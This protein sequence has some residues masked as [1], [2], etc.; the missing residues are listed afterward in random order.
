MRALAWDGDKLAL[1]SSHHVP[2]ADDRMA[3]V[4]VNLAGI[5][6]TDLQIFKGYMGFR[7]VPGHEFVGTV[8]DGPESL[9]GKRVVGEINFG[10]GQCE[11]CRRDLNRHCPNRSVMGILNAAGAFAEY[12]AVPAANLH[13]VP[14]KVSDEEAVF[15]EPLAAAFEILE[16][17]QIDPGDQV[18]VLGDGK[19][20]NLCA[21]VL[22]L[23]GA[24]V[25]A[26]GKHE[27][28]L[29]LIKR[30]G[31]RTILLTDWTPRL[32]DIVVEATGSPSGLEL[33]LGAVRPRG[34]LILKSTI[35][36]KHEISLAPIVIN[37]ITVIG[38]RC[39]LFAPALEGLEEKS[40]SVAPLIEKIYPLI[41][42]TEA[43]EHATRQ[44]A[45]KILLR[46]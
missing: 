5:C 18:L 34:T 23:T 45:R 1:S 12:V 22:R 39:G 29:K 14:D 20:G 46:P 21:Q 28:K 24:T 19:L 2:R 13:L 7:G 32:F 8:S 17:V 41:D 30:A 36:G 10:C 42:G 35:A 6:S 9:L 27:D 37:E 31:V 4:K 11:A 33:A 15:T 3:V 43:V 40:V 16:Q 25:T 26:L 44:G 38:S